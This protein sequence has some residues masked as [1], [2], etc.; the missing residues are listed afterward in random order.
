[1][2]TKKSPV[3]VTVKVSPPEGVKEEETTVWLSIDIVDELRF[4]SLLHENLGRVDDFGLG[5]M[6][7]EMGGTFSVSMTLQPEFTSIADQL[8]ALNACVDLDVVKFTVA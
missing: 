5:L 6:E 2:P 7:A 3:D 4:Y 8:E 1:M